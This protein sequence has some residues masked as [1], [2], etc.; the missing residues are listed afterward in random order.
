MKSWILRI[1]FASALLVLGSMWGYR[2]ATVV[3]AQATS[4]INIPK[5]WGPVIGTMT[6]VLVLQDSAGTLR[7]VAADTGQLGEVVTRN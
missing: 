1:V 5:A 3:H 7:L 4:T 6:G 2:S